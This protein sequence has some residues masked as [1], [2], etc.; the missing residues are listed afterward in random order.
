MSE[1]LIVFSALLLS[2]SSGYLFHKMYVRN[3]LKV[4]EKHIKSVRTYMQTLI[5]IDKEMELE[6]ESRLLSREDR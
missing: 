3:H 4:P 1:A 5:Q 6:N 2:F